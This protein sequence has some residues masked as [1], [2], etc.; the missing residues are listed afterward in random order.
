VFQRIQIAL[1]TFGNIYARDG[2]TIL[3]KGSSNRIRGAEGPGSGATNKKQT[4]RS[5][6]AQLFSN[7][8]HEIRV[9]DHTGKPRPFYL[10][11]GLSQFGHIRH[12]NESPLGGRPDIDKHGTLIIP[13]NT[14]RFSR[15]H[16]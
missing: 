16:L 15:Q 11:N 4:R 14:P 3:T 5:R 2:Q 13:Q 6:S 1:E 8:A 9:R 12:A 10:K 7:I